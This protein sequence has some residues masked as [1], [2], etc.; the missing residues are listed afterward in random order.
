MKETK[1]FNTNTCQCFALHYI[2][3]IMIKN[4]N[5]QNFDILHFFSNN[6]C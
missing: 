2:L 3:V 5:D 1:I 4:F 6:T